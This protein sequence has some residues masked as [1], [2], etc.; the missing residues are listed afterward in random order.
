MHSRFSDCYWNNHIHHSGIPTHLQG[1]IMNTS[2]TTILIQQTT[3]T[4]PQI[5]LNVLFQL[6]KVNFGKIIENDGSQ[7]TIEFPYPIYREA[8]TQQA[9]LNKIRFYLD[10]DHYVVI[11]T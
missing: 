8:F 9:I 1:L 5:N 4:T 10:G 7:L 3:T 2:F 6:V 11:P